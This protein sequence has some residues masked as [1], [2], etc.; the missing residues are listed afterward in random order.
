M[1]ACFD[2]NSTVHPLVILGTMRIS[3]SVWNFTPYLIRKNLDLYCLQWI[4]LSQDM[5][6]VWGRV[7]GLAPIIVAELG[8]GPEPQRNVRC[9]SSVVDSALDDPPL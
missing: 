5:Y 4:N 6:V 2:I 9:R 7:A 1:W 8:V 3:A